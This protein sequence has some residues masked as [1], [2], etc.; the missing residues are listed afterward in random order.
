MGIGGGKLGAAEVTCILTLHFYAFALQIPALIIGTT[1]L[2]LGMLLLRGIHARFDVRRLLFLGAASVLMFAPAFLK[3][4]HGFSPVYYALSSLVSLG[5]ANVITRDVEVLRLAFVRL[6]WATAALLC[7]L[8]AMNEGSPEP[9]GELIPGSS[10]NG[11]PAYLII[12]QIGLSL[13]SYASLQRLPLLSPLMTFFIAFMGNGRGS[14]VV[15]ALLIAGT[16]ALGVLGGRHSSFR[17]KAWIAASVATLAI[18]AVVYGD[19]AFEY[20]LRHTKLSVGLEDRNRGAILVQYLAKLDAFTVLAGASY[21]G[22]LISDVYNGNP[23]IAYVRAHS[24]FG[25]FYTILALFS[26]A[27][28]LPGRGSLWVKAIF[29]YFLT[30]AV[31]RAASEPVLFPTL[32]D[33]VYFSC[34]FLYF[35]RKRATATQPAV[36][37]GASHVAA[38]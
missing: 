9:L 23:H 12:M 8:L 24:F 4:W 6:Y 37:E 35:R 1:L 28:I 22:T 19:L 32:L 38:A 30:L 13:S 16:L 11:I 18:L 3:P 17:R 21:E 2:M 34:F 5:V 14:L 25:L 15:A 31:V 33:V 10:T 26:P 36:T 27:L 29:I 20:V 7:A